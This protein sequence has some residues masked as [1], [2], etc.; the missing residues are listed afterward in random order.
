M[1]EF[2][3]TIHG[4]DYA[5]E[6]I[7][8]ED[9]I[10]RLEVNGTPYNVEIHRKVKTSKTPR[11]IAP[12]EKAPSQ[13]AIEKRSRGDAHPI[14]AP[15]PG[16][17]IAIRV[18]PGDIIEKGQVLMIMEAMK[19]ENQVLSDRKGVVESISVNVSDTVL[20]GDILLHLI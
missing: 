2:K 16:N 3:F 14:S 15:L 17:I 19:M 7:E 12:P 18:S 11:V 4:T 6:L 13:P 10:A 20:Q 9:N 5:V 8:I 1:K